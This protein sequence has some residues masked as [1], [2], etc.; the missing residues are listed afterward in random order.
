LHYVCQARFNLMIFT[1]LQVLLKVVDFR[2]ISLLLFQ[3]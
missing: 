3:N 2:K 1:T